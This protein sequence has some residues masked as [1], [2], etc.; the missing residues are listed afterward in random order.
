[1]EAIYDDI[2]QQIGF[3][4]FAPVVPARGPMFSAAARSGKK[5]AGPPVTSERDLYDDPTA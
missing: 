1:M 3:M 4:A 2:P 5:S